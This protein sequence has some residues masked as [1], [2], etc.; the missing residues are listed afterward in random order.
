M[1]IAIHMCNY[2]HKMSILYPLPDKATLQEKCGNK[3]VSVTSAYGMSIGYFYHTPKS[4]PRS[5]FQI[6]LISNLIYMFKIEAM[7]LGGKICKSLYSSMLIPY[8]GG[9]VTNIFFLFP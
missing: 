4:L 8:A 9:H 1:L 3:K 5:N 6:K 2:T 7:I